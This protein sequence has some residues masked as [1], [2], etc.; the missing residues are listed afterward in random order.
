MN[1]LI[2]YGDSNT[3]GW[4]PRGPLITCYDRPWVTALEELSGISCVNKGRPGR[5][6]PESDA[7]LST[8]KRVVANSHGDAMLILLGTNNRFLAPNDSASETVR[9]MDALLSF[10]RSEFPDFPLLLMG[11]PPL[12]IPGEESG[13]WVSEVNTLYAQLAEKYAIPYYDPKVELTLAFDGVHLSEEAHNTLGNDLY[14][15][16]KEIEFIKNDPP[17]S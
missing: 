5:R 6:I 12:D 14:A 3:F 8:L 13:E 17:E 16:L 2:C 9:K 7:E 15:F 1:K 4:D 10:L 11:L